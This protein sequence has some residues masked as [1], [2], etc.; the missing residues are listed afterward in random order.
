MSIGRPKPLLE[1]LAVD[2]KSQI[3]AL[4]RTQPVLPMGL[5]YLEGVTH[6]DV[7]HG[8]AT[9]QRNPLGCSSSPKLTDSRARPPGNSESRYLLSD[10]VVL[11]R[12]HGS[13]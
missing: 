7:R 2:E 6:D 1:V 10:T 5:G 8:T 4:S 3:Q 13:G 9:G 12:R 11:R